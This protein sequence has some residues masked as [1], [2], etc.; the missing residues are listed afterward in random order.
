MRQKVAIL[1]IATGC[2][3][4]AVFAR[5]HD[6]THIDYVVPGPQTIG[7][8]VSVQRS[9]RRTPEPRTCDVCSNRPRMFYV[10]DAA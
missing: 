7:S 3:A 6:C 5:W 4:I 2:I 10:R 1:V 9:E 8:S